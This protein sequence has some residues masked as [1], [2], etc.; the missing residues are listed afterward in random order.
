MAYQAQKEVNRV[1]EREKKQAKAKEAELR[2][3][4][5]ELKEDNERQQNLIG[6][7]S[8]MRHNYFIYSNV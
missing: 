8:E 3:E 7:V 6:Q 2:K 4:I 5:K 1:L